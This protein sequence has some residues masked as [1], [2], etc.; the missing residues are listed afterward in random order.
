MNEIQGSVEPGWAA[1]A[2]AFRTNF[3]EHGELGAA[4]A[5]YVD[6]RPVADLWGGVADQRSGRPWGEVVR[7]A[8]GRTIGAIF[9]DEVAGPLGLDAWIG[10]PEEIEDRVALL[11]PAGE[12]VLDDPQLDALLAQ[13]M[14]PDSVIGRAL[15]LGGA[16][17]AN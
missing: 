16:V 17:P 7:R 14:G 1:V 11:E 6:G 8:T 2:D 13:A 9:A 4:C 3:S 15:S 12:I 10:L 5:I